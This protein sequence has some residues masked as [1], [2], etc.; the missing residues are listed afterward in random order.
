MRVDGEALVFE[1]QGW[2]RTVRLAAGT[3][4]IEVTRVVVDGRVMESDG[5]TEN[6]QLYAPAAFNRVS[7]R[8]A[9][10][11]RLYYTCYYTAAAISTSQSVETP[12]RP[13]WVCHSTP[14]R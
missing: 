6:A 7:N 13:V 5:K 11:W 3:L 4:T 10:P 8:A 12:I 2:R 14:D 1:G 9:C